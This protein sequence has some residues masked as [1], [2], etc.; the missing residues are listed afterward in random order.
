MQDIDIDRQFL[1]MND[2]N[3]IIIQI[4]Y[5]DKDYESQSISIALGIIN[6]K[7]IIRKLTH[8]IKQLPEPKPVKIIKLKK[9]K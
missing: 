2:G 7:N 6:A 8:H 1:V 5:K 3:N 4:N 9:K